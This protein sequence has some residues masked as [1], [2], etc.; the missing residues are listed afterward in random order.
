MQI[1]GLTRAGSSIDLYIYE[2][3]QKLGEVRLG[4]GSLIW[5]GKWKGQNKSLRLRWHKFASLMNGIASGEIK[6]RIP[7]A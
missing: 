3:G 6:L 2:D 7:N 5:T 4:R 1:L